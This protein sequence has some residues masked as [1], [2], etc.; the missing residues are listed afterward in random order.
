MLMSKELTGKKALDWILTDS[1]NN[2]VALKDFKSKV[3]MIEFTGIGC[4]PCHSAIPF[5]KQLVTDYKITD[6]ELTGI[7]AWSQDHRC[8][9][10]V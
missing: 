9:K 4:G 3:L 10:A 6:F 5:L 2:S 7:E 8:S 1:E